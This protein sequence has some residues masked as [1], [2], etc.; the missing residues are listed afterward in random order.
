VNAGF[1]R[2]G[3]VCKN[4]EFACRS[5]SRESI[6]D[7]ILFEAAVGDPIDAGMHRLMER[8]DSRSGNTVDRMFPIS[9]GNGTGEYRDLSILVT[10]GG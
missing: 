1:D 8:D 2:R 10:A 7:R 6:G 3:V 4:R 9:I 5:R